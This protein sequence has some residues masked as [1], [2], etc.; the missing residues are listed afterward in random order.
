MSTTP[1][2]PPQ[3][4][5][6]E[7]TP[8]TGSTLVLLRGIVGGAVGGVVGYLLFRW[9]L[10]KGF[11]ALVLPGALLGLGAGLAARGRSQPLAI[12]CAAAAICLAFYAEW[13]RAPFAK[14]GTFVYFVTHLHE[15]NG[16][17]VKLVM[18][19]LG[20]LCAYWFGQGR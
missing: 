5:M 6:R 9:L 16:A 8:Q 15:L 1:I 13:V 14:D 18:I 10:S 17:S 2:M 11:Y 3:E 19:A 12:V 20:A 7:Y 4:T